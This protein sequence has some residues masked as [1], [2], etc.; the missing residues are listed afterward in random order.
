MNKGLAIAGGVLILLSILGII[1]GVVGIAGHGPDSE[2]IL[3]DT[4]LDGNTFAFNGN[5]VLLEIYA[6]GDVDCYSYTVSVTDDLYEYFTKN[7]DAGTEAPG[8]TYL[9]DLKLSMPAITS[10]I[11]TVML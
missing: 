3:H 11:Q 4:E 9:G 2:N 6:K 7:C 1:I 8:Y 5:I 10:S